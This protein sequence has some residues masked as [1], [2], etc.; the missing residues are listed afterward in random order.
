MVAAV[1][2]DIRFWKYISP[3]PN[4]GCWLWDGGVNACGYGILGVFQRSTLAHRFSYQLHY[5]DIPAGLNVLHRCDVPC[6]VNPEHLFLGTQN[7]NVQDMERK[8]RSYH[9]RGEA[10]GRA[11]LTESDV[12]AIRADTRAS[13]AIAEDFGVS[14]LVIRH[15]KKRKLWSHVL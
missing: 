6:C 9:P 1:A 5:G 10:H 13:R 15:I 4:S 12:V 2:P 14:K 8:A 3:E 7:D 11:K